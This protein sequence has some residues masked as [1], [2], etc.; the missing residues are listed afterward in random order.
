MLH[1]ETVE[2]RTFSILEAIMKMPE[3][4]EFSLVGGTALSLLYGHRISIDLDLFS[5]VKF[6]NDK[7]TNALIIK[8]GNSIDIRSSSHFGIFC[9]IEDVKI[10]VVR[11]PHPLIRPVI[12]IDQIRMYSPEDIVA[13]KVQA[14]LGRGKKKDFFDIAELLDHFTI[15]D[16][17]E[18]HKEKFATQN[19]MI[20]IPHAITYY[21]DANESENPVSLK[22]Q[23]WS[24]VKSTINK[25][26]KSY[27]KQ[28]L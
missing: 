19:I 3:L 16:F 7:I 9:F 26:V 5:N 21:N 17:I 22:N 10:D 1:L 25:K 18:F 6:E 15:E 20:T 27:F 8:F 24:S 12:E 28:V 11:F 23:K 13:M 2:P 14:I 4:Q